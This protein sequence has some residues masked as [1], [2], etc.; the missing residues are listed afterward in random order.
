MTVDDRRNAG[1][2]PDQHGPCGGGRG[3]GREAARAAIRA[4]A[5]LDLAAWATIEPRVLAR[6]VPTGR[7]SPLRRRLP[8]PDRGEPAR[9]AAVVLDVGVDVEGGIVRP[10]RALITAWA[11]EPDRIWRVAVA[12]LDL[13]PGPTVVT[14]Q[15][16]PVRLQVLTGGPWTSGRLLLP[17][18]L[19]VDPRSPVLVAAPSSDLLVVADRPTPTPGGAG[20]CPRECL[21]LPLLALAER[22]AAAA[23]DPLPLRPIDPM[24]SSS[25]PS[26]RFLE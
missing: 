7:A 3:E 18:R 8:G 22:L 17:H 5:G 1:G 23:A 2:M 15:R 10:D 12:N 9:P 20:P 25:F 16:E 6:V 26:Q 4:V 24:R 14:V 19:P 13:L 21:A 11:V